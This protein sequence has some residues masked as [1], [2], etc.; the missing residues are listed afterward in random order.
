MQRTYASVDMLD[1]PF[2]FAVVLW[3]ERFRNYFLYYCLPSLLSPGN[4]PSL[5]TRRPSKFLIATLPDDWAAMRE[6]AIFKK[7]ESYIEPVYLEIPACPPG[8]HGCEHIGVG[9]KLTCEV[10]FREKAYAVHATPDCMFSDGAIARVQALAREGME[11]V[12]CA[13]LRFAEEPVFQNLQSR[14]L[15]PRQCARDT[16]E[17]LVLPA[18][19]LTWAAINGL[20]SETLTYEWEGPYFAPRP[21]AAWWRVPDEDGVVLHCLSWFPLLLDF[22][23]VKELDVS[24]LDYW[25]IDGDFLH[26]NVGSSEA[27]HVVEDS[28]E[29][30]VVSWTPSAERLESTKRLALLEN[31]SARELIHAV[32]LRRTYY[33]PYIDQ[34]KRRMFVHT[35]R[36]H[37]RPLTGAWR[38]VENKASQILSA[39]IDEVRAGGEVPAPAWRSLVRITCAVSSVCEPMVHVWFHHGAVRR[40][41]AQILRGDR[42]A[43]RRALWHVERIAYEFWGRPFNKSAPKPPA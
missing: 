32:Q 24:M 7:L 25:T 20:H 3:G 11:V 26:R 9:H 31:T 6:T 4:I 16:G 34:F 23:S 33:G 15:I 12:V 28:D 18:R 5:A 2:H 13:A 17:P 43:M 42:D 39:F 35:V 37:G 14:G 40:R 21:A 36:W 19:D 30:F 27:V 41:L 29:A 10:S 1:R 22:A 38:Q 8:R